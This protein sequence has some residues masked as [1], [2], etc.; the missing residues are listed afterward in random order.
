MGAGLT[1]KRKLFQNSFILVLKFWSRYPLYEV[2]S[3]DD[4]SVLSMSVMGSDKKMWIGDGWVVWA[5]SNFFGEFFF[6][7][8][9]AKPLSN[10][11][12]FCSINAQHHIRDE[13]GEKDEVCLLRSDRNLAHSFSKLWNVGFSTKTRPVTK[14]MLVACTSAFRSP[15]S[16]TKIV[17][18]T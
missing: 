2:V 4:L 15:H 12:I 14:P 7:C 1:W 10:I 8:Y 9:F 18:R 5:L 17:A 6:F 11:L 13:N 16:S 3:Y